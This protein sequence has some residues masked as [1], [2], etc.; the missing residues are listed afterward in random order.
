[1]F[2][3]RPDL[4]V[5]DLGNVHDQVRVVRRGPKQP[6]FRCLVWIAH[7]R[8]RQ[9]IARTRPC[10]IK[11][12]PPD[13]SVIGMLPVPRRG[14]EGEQHVWAAP[15]DLSN[16]LTPKLKGLDQARVGVAEELHARYAK[17]CGSGQLLALSQ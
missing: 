15:P 8:V 16:K 9:A 1:M 17:S 5:E 6:S 13:D 7:L 2:E 12:Q 11:R 3:A 14:I 4:I 10:S